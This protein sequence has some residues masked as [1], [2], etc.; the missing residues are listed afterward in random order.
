VPWTWWPHPDPIDHMGGGGVVL[1]QVELGWRRRP[2]SGSFL[3]QGA[4]VVVVRLG[5]PPSPLVHQL[6]CSVIVRPPEKHAIARGGGCHPTAVSPAV[7][8]WSS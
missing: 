6:A 1:L 4:R 7:V 2:S 5:W 8:E 3:H